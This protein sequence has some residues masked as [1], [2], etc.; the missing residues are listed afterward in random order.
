[1]LIPREIGPYAVLRP[2]AKGGLAEVYEV[3]DPATGEHHAIKLLIHS[4]KAVQRFNREYKIIT[5]INHPNILRVYR[6]GIHKGQPWIA[7]ELLDGVALQTHVKGIGPP[8]NPERTKEVLRIGWFLAS[9]LGYL[10]GR[11]LI[12][13]DIKS[14]N[15]VVL[16]DGRVKLLDFGTAHIADAAEAITRSEE[17]VGTFAYASPEQIQS[18]EIDG[19]SDIYALGVLLYRLAAG[20]RPFDSTDNGE[21]V[22]MHLNDIP[23]TPSSHAE[24][25]PEALDR[26]ILWMLEKKPA[27]RPQSAEIVN[28]YLTTIAGEAPGPGGQLV[29]RQDRAPGRGP[30]MRRLVDALINKGGPKT[31][32]LHGAKG[33]A[34]NRV[35]ERLEALMNSVNWRVLSVTVKSKHNLARIATVLT[36]LSMTLPQR[37]RLSVPERAALGLLAQHKTTN[38]DSISNAIK[39]LSKCEENMLL[40]VNEVHLAS[41]QGRLLLNQC[42]RLVN[43]SKGGLRILVVGD[44]PIPAENNSTT[45]HIGL[46]PLTPES[47]SVAVGTM[48]HRRPI[49]MHAARKL[50]EVTGGQPRYLEEVV[51]RLIKSN[52]LKVSTS[53]PDRLVI[54]E[55]PGVS[56]PTPRSFFEAIHHKLGSIPIAHREIIEM[57]SLLGE[58]ASLSIAADAVSWDLPTMRG[59]VARVGEDTGLFHIRRASPDLVTWESPVI[60]RVIADSIGPLRRDYLARMSSESLLAG[61][62]THEQLALVADGHSLEVAVVAGIQIAS[63]EIH[64][65]PAKV[66]AGL[67][68]LVRRVE[69]GDQNTSHLHLHGLFLYYA[70]ALISLKP[71]HSEIK[72]SLTRARAYARKTGGQGLANTMSVLAEFHG[73]T[74]HL[75][76]QRRTLKSALDYAKSAEDIKMQVDLCCR[77]VESSLWYGNPDD[78]LNWLGQAE[79]LADSNSDPLVK[80]R[81]AITRAQHHLISGDLSNALTLCEESMKVFDAGGEGWRSRLASPL[82]SEI[83]RQQGRLSEATEVLDV[84]LS[85]ARAT[86]NPSVLV[87]ILVG[88]GHC[89]L[90]LF[91]LG[92]AQEIVDEIE[93]MGDGDRHLLH[94]L[95]CSL[96]KGRLNNACEH[97]EEALHGLQKAQEFAE[98]AG[99]LMMVER[100]RGLTARTFLG[101]KKRPEA[102]DAARVAWEGLQEYENSLHLVEVSLTRMALESN[103]PVSDDILRP[104]A[105]IM[106]DP[107]ALRPRLER[108]I[109]LIRWH[110][111]RANANATRAARADAAI[112]LDELSAQLNDTD[113]ASLRVHPLSATISGAV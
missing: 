44:E 4:G 93:S 108:A 94:T 62:L 74:G 34:R 84:Q 60:Y 55:R 82:L 30:A 45:L 71:S 12:H 33:S 11:G 17:F 65:C 110:R 61:T 92:R 105:H 24:G 3:Q 112:Y 37:S 85:H 32:F 26:L 8:G 96:L 20:R 68:P 78:T 75:D 95:E 38:T 97:W 6:Y 90:D 50:F 83:L 103:I 101:Q 67:Q 23:T 59:V 52:R 72:E 48:L 91:R 49:S 53:A 76:T 36:K 47:L 99:L 102:C 54:D 56:M 25:L 5:T 73:A 80:A 64:N 9:A 109:S 111:Q 13:R 21:L 14:A 7:M 98:S 113:I 16:P 88:L 1:V 63:E 29:L 58:V 86:E 31:I 66:L 10:H 2:I 41:P 51:D 18:H 28:N 46:S 39:T 57:L 77:L 104:T 106:S 107:T 79:S 87:P 22:R 15:A 70:Q 69:R 42:L 19:R 27:D 40:V 43:D 89:H 35:S 100:I 81:Y